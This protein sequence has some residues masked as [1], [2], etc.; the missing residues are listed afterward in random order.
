M[1][2]DCGDQLHASACVFWDGVMDG[3]LHGEPVFVCLTCG[4]QIKNADI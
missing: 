2:L 3:V 4:E 1:D